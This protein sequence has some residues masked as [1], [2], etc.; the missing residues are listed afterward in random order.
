MSVKVCYNIYILREGYKM[1]VLTPM[2]TAVKFEELQPFLGKVSEDTM[3]LKI[4]KSFDFD[5]SD[6]EQV[7]ALH[8]IYDTLTTENI[9]ETEHEI[10]KRKI[11]AHIKL[12]EAKLK[13]L[14]I[15]G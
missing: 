9:K 13:A 11:K 7:K 10:E 6:P 8:F 3:M 12:L 4:K 14:E 5:L 1:K 15:V 2:E